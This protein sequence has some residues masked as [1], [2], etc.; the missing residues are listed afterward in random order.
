MILSLLSVSRVW[1]SDHTLFVYNI[2]DRIKHMPKFISPED[3][4]RIEKAIFYL[5]EKYRE[6][7]R[8]PKPV[9]LHS[10]RVGIYLLELGYETDIIITGILHDLPEDSEVSL[11]DIAKV[12]SSDMAKW[13]DAVSFRSD[14]DDPVE[15]YREMFERTIAAGRIPVIVKA[16]DL[17]IN[18]LYIHLVPDLKKQRMLIQKISYFLS[19]TVP[20][21]SEPVIEE[22]RIRFNDEK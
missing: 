8:N 15:Q 4:L 11:E 2:I 14:I 9:V 13:I 1:S 21:R 22:L 17:L 19:K 20:F 10:I 6:S 18:S 7:G 12:F 16:A 3:S 5:A